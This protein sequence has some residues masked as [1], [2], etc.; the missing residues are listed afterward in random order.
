MTWRVLIIEDEPELQM[1]LRDNLQLEGYAVRSAE[2]GELGV[3]LALKEHPDVV[4]LDLSLPKMSGQAVCRTLRARGLDTRI[5]MLT[6]RNTEADRIAGLDGGADDYVG[7]PFSLGELMARVRAQVRERHPGRPAPSGDVRLG[8]VTVN[9]RDRE[10]RSGTTV[11][12]LT[13][14]EFDLLQYFIEHQGETLSR[15][16]LLT[17]VWGY[18]NS[19]VTR[20]VDNFVARLRRHIEADA[21][22]PR[23][24]LTVHG[25]GYRLVP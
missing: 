11:V 17:Q 25:S 5:I 3:E 13:T 23:H 1:V 19:V 20:T 16:R 22:R 21:L 4:I 15:Q 9:L 6:V 18:E 2:S 24:L 10:V 14:R 8:E 12:A 7:K